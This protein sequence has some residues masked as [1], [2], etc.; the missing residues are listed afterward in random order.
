MGKKQKNQLIVSLGAA[1]AERRKSKGLTQ[2]QLAAALG[3][4]QESL[5]LI[6]TGEN[7]PRIQRLQDIADV[8]S[9]SVADLFRKV[10]PETLK[11]GERIAEMI[12]ALPV[13]FQD[14]VV[15]MVANTVSAMNEALRKSKER[16]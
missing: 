6:E 2:G 8:L 7:A 16:T 11:K 13:P 4:A 9:C 1:I 15:S 14:V 3:I 5:C 12:Y 10:S